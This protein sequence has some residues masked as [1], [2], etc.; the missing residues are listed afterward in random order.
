M[1]HDIA[2]LEVRLQDLGEALTGLAD[3]EAIGETLRYIH[4]PG[5][6]TPAEY[7]LVNELVSALH[8]QVE[9]MREMTGAL[10]AGAREIGTAAKVG[11]QA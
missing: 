1:P 8:A 10:V 7:L 11:A 9:V 6:T 3:C 5:W 4:Q 2:R